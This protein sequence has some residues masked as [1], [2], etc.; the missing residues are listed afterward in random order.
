MIQL[1]AIDHRG[2]PLAQGMDFFAPPP[3]EIGAL[4]SAHSNL[5]Q[6]ER[7]YE[8]GNRLAMTLGLGIAGAAGGW[9]FQRYLEVRD[10]SWQFGWPALGF[11]GLAIGA[12]LA[13]EFSKTVSYV[14]QQGIAR[15]RCKKTRD[16]V[17]SQDVFLF[18]KAVELRTGQTRHY[19]N[20]V[21]TGTTYFFNWT[22]QGG[23]TVYTLQGRYQSEKGDPAAGDQYHWASAAE[24]AW[25]NWY[26]NDPKVA[27][28]GTLKFFLSS[29]DCVAV[30]NGYLDLR[31]GGKTARCDCAD[32]ASVTINNG[33][34]TIKRKDASIGWFS[35]TGVFSFPYA[36][37]GN[38]KI[39]MF[40]LDRLAG[41]SIN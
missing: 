20:G 24:I 33:Q 18:E 8:P 32:I 31:F 13:T 19:T 34:F 5:K 16:E 40:A 36:S 21:Y 3:T 26:I 7:P 6:D 23:K 11:L 4:K 2:E 29:G 37:M 9:W 22:N 35:S 15:I 41:L 14:G 38:V 25:S 12:W 1:P 28:D 39:F 17:V 30:G 27:A 10:P